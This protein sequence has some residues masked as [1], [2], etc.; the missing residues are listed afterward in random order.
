MHLSA[1][2]SEDH[3]LSLFLFPPF[4]FTE[5]NSDFTV[6]YSSGYSV[7]CSFSRFL[8]TGTVL[9]PRVAFR[10]FVGLGKQSCLR[11]P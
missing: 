7:A 5:E 11:S 2:I 10:L 9:G 1:E 8:L 3:S 4:F 6:F